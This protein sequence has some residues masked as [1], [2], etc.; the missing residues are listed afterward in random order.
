MRNI[1]K[2]IVLFFLFCACEK[3]KTTILDLGATKDEI[4]RI[5]LR[6]DHKTLIPDGISKMEF[7]T[8]VYGKKK[9]QSYYKDDEGNMFR[10]KWKRSI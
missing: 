2:Y 5:E 1:I 3:E 7:Y 8:F 10:K 4:S 6:A 9:V